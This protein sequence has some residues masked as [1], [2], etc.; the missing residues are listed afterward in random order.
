MKRILVIL[1]VPLFL[2]FDSLS[3]DTHFNKDSTTLRSLEHRWLTAEFRLDTA[4]ISQL[5]D[6]AF[7]SIGDKAILTKQE[8]LDGILKNISQRLKNNHL[9]D[10]LHFDDFVVKIYGNTAIVTFISVTKGTVKGV[11]FSNRKTR[12]YDVWIK[13]EGQWKAVSS[14]ITPIR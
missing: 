14:Q 8:E 1:L 10:S 3:Q 11:A 7:I 12:I 6:H 5:M 4:T 9:V 13:K 2:P